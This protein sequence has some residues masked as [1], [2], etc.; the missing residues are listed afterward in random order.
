MRLGS[1][2]FIMPAFFFFIDLRAEETS[3]DYAGNKRSC[4]P[5]AKAHHCAERNRARDAI[6]GIVKKS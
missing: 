4:E 3:K 6:N 1:F 2:G 5:N